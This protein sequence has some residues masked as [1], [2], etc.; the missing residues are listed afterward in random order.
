M[1]RSWLALVVAVAFATCATLTFAP[2]HDPDLWWHLATGRAALKTSSTLPVDIFSFSFAGAP[3]RYKDLIADVSLWTLFAHGGFAALLGMRL[4]CTAGMALG[5][6][7]VVERPLALLVAL[8]GL[9]LLP[10]ADRPN[11]LSLAL[12]PLLLALL[13]RRRFVWLVVLTWMWIAIHRAALLG[14][15]LVAARAF[16]LGVA[17]LVAHRRRISIAVGEP[18]AK[19]ALFAAFIAAA[20]AP[21]VGLLNPAGVAAFRTGLG[22]T[23]SAMLRVYIAEWKNV[24]LPALWGWHGA[25]AAV[26]VLAV[27]GRL[28]AAVR[29]GERARVDAWHSALVIAFA[30]AATR[31]VRF[32]PYLAL[33]ATYVLA[34]FVDEIGQP[35]TAARAITARSATVVASV[36]LVVVAFAARRSARWSLDADA[37]TVPV[38]AVD[39]ARA[40]GLTGPVLHSY[41]FGGYLLFR[42][43]P[44]LVDGRLDQVYPLPFVATCIQSERTPS[45]LAQL[46]LDDVGWALA[47]NNDTRFTHRYLFYDPAWAEIYWSEAASV[48][49]RRDLHPEL[50]PFAFAAID[51]TA[52]E[53]SVGD[54]VRSGDARRIAAAHHDLGR[55]VAASPTSVRANGALAIFFHLTGHTNERDT[56]MRALRI[57]APDHPFVRELDRRF[58]PIL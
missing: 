21:L 45:F 22:V 5:F 52:P 50:V 16:H 57:M 27:V 13:E 29:R 24:G 23:G 43:V 15:A 54:V 2:V 37:I 35:A 36:G 34:R 40:H 47:S 42:G 17:Q 4:A 18:P 58:G 41:E 30:I 38:A 20:V 53:R 1:P 14:Y 48:Y 11:L 51:P 12:F 6:A 49:V 19:R 7:R 56:V 9:L 8:A 46:P 31:S 10:W 44:V 3:W 25:L 28:V 39:F 33:A 32:L 55:M 26:A